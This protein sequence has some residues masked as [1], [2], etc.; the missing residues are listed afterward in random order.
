MINNEFLKDKRILITG[1][2]GYLGSNLLHELLKYDV[3]SIRGV[4]RNESKL[5]ELQEK[6]TDDR[7]R[8][9]IGDIRDLNRMQ[10]AVEGVDIIYHCAAIKHID[11]AQRNVFE[12]IQTNVIGTQN[13]IDLAIENNTEQFIGFDTDKS[14]GGTL[15]VYGT[16]K[17]LMREQI[18]TANYIKGSH[19]TKFGCMRW[20]NILDS[21]MSVIPKWKESIKNNTIS[22]TEPRMTRFNLSINEVIQFTLSCQENMVGGEVFIPE[23]KSYNLYEL[24]NSFIEKYGNKLTNVIY[25]KNRGSEKKDEDLLDIGEFERIYKIKSGYVVVPEEKYLQEFGLKYNY[26]KLPYTDRLYSLKRYSSKDA[27]KLTKQDLKEMI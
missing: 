12:A 16:T 14:C 9:Y 17:K 15:N 26:D 8:L 2:S 13:L 22:I 10:K 6:V 19:K 23:M 24:A 3:H 7:V 5:S 20:G 4:S 25:I 11:L 1:I 21:S 27:I 18:I